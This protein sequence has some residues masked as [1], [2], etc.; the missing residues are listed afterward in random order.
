MIGGVLPKAIL[1]MNEEG[2][3]VM[4]PDF[5]RIIYGPSKMNWR[6]ERRD[7]LVKESNDIMWIEF[8][9]EGKGKSKHNQPAI[10]RSLIMSP[11]NDFFTW[12]TTA[13]TEI[14][15]QTEDRIVFRTQNSH[16]ILSRLKV[17]NETTEI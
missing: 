7:G 2:K 9:E 10:G 15:E 14:I 8:D 4:D 13:V 11:F 16:Y 3:L 1:Q 5:E 17:T 12:Q 6:L